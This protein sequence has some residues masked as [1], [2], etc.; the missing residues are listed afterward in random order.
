[1]SGDILRMSA[2]TVAVSACIVTVQAD[3]GAYPETSFR[4]PETF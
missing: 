1:M 4:C 2:D 3:I